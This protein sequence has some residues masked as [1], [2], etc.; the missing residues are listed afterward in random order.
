MREKRLRRKRTFNMN[1]F[2]LIVLV[3]GLLAFFY[4]ALFVNLWAFGYFAAVALTIF[5]IYLI[6]EVMRHED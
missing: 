4:Y 2:F 1:K 5:F 3:L 6:K